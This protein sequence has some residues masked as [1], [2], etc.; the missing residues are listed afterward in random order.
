MVNCH[1]IGENRVINWLLQ[2]MVTDALTV[3][4]IL[5]CAIL[6]LTYLC[7]ETEGTP[8]PPFIITP[9]TSTFFGYLNLDLAS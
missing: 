3:T 7:L 4:L 5:A 6:V 1:K 9:W 2:Y 8:I